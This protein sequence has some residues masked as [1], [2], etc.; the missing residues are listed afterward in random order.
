MELLS[1]LHWIE[2]QASNVYLWRSGRGLIM[3]DTGMPGDTNKILNYLPE[4]GFK[5][6]D[7]LAILITHADIDHAGGA[8]ALSARCE[9]PILASPE[10]TRLLAKGKSPKHL[11]RIAQFVTDHFFGYK[12]VPGEQ[13]RL[14]EDG[15]RLPEFEEWQ[16][17]A[18]PGHCSDHFSFYSPGH[19]VVFAGDALN[20]RDD[21]LGLSAK[22]V[23]ADQSLAAQSARR[24]LELTPAVIACGHGRPFVDHDA[25][26]IMLVYRQLGDLMVQ[27]GDARQ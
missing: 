19:G 8:A 15:Q 26:D 10:T 11:P 27:T 25:A 4:H 5:P 13:L 14:V 12:P 17:I 7:V 2:G 24:L 18:T 21:K 23:T 9:A 3:V 1:N 20:T 6:Q 16:A 22:R